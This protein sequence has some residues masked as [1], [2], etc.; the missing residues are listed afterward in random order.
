MD[1]SDKYTKQLLTEAI[2]EE[3]SAW[4]TESVMQQIVSDK[5]TKQPAISTKSIVV[6]SILFIG[7][8]VWAIFLTIGSNSVQHSLELFQYLS[9]SQ[10]LPSFDWSFSYYPIILIVIVSLWA[11]AL[12]D[13][14]IGQFGY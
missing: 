5:E 6:F 14:V 8:F 2:N 3:P 1:Q 12:F 9:L 4:F 11:L 13:W 10:Y 7:L